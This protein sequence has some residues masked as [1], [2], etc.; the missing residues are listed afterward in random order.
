MPPTRAPFAFTT[1]PVPS[2]LAK[3][4]PDERTPE[5]LT[6]ERPDSFCT[7]TLPPLS[8]SGGA[9]RAAVAEAK[10]PSTVA[11]VARVR[12]IRLV[13]LVVCRDVISI[14]L[15]SMWTRW[16]LR[17]AGPRVVRREHVRSVSAVTY[18][19]ARAVAPARGDRRRRCAA[20][21]LAL[22]AADVRPQ[23]DRLPPGRPGRLPAPAREGPRGGADHDAAREHGDG[24]RPQPRRQL[25]RDGAR[26]CV[27]AHG[28]GARAGGDGDARRLPR[29]LPAAPPRSPVR[30]R[31]ALLVPR[32]RGADARGAAPRGA[33]P[34]GRAAGAAPSLRADGGRRER[35]GGRGAA[36]AGATRGARRHDARDRQPRSAR[37]GETGNRRAP[38]RAD[39]RPRPRA[40]RAPGE[41][42]VRHESDSTSGSTRRACGAVPRRT[43]RPSG[44][45]RGRGPRSVPRRRGA[46]PPRSRR[47]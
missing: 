36:D 21:D 44:C 38:P 10:A 27:A 34:A 19:P 4:P 35:G 2:T 37:G 24:R 23:R 46:A 41:V 22:A 1:W 7:R 30:R 3:T 39:D 14:L 9:T 15:R 16:T 43:G 45:P 11:A 6:R 26:R 5:V 8:P 47:A 20:T 17:G 42:S 12:S 18:D 28:D 32:R 40:D 13:V 31:A 33:L 25:R 29:G